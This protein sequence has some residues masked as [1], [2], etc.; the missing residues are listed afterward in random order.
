MKRKRDTPMSEVVGD[1]AIKQQGK[2]IVGSSGFTDD[3]R[4]E[5]EKVGVRKVPVLN[6]KAD[7]EQEKK[8][9]EYNER[10]L[11]LDPLYS[12]LKPIQKVLVRCFSKEVTRTESGIIIPPDEIQIP[13]PTKS[14]QGYV[15]TVKSPWAFST[16]AIIV[17]VPTKYG[18]SET[19]P[20]QAGKQVQLAGNVLIPRKNGQEMIF[21]MPSSFTHWSYQSEKIPENMDDPHYGYF[22]INSL[23]IDVI[24][25]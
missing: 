16:R 14:G 8:I 25:D 3:E 7:L 10:I 13:V 18:E 20:I 24:L 11:T 6:D 21:H 4:K 15:E 12:S 17:A 1:M 23:D 5:Y 19:N 2:I 9:K 22:L